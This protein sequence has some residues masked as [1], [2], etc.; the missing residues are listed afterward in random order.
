MTVKSN[1]KLGTLIGC[2]VFIPGDDQRYQEH[3]APWTTLTMSS[4]FKDPNAFS[5]PED[6]QL[7]KEAKKEFPEPIDYSM[8]VIDI[9]RLSL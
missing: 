4:A 1:H 5:D 7:V 2:G 8:L 9:S 3:Y 6:S